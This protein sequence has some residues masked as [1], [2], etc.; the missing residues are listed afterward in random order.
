MEE[1]L[2]TYP[3]AL[4]AKE[5]GFDIPVKYGVYGKKMKLTSMENGTLC[6]WNADTKQQERSKATSVPTQSILNKWIR[7]N[8]NVVVWL[9]PANTEYNKWSIYVDDGYG[10]HILTEYIIVRG[11]EEALERGLEVAL[12]LM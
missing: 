3:V 2:V 12:E 4:L 9:K 5:K 7:E 1:Q 8:K 6:N 11:Y 10:R